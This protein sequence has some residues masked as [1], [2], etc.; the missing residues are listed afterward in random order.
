MLV[1]YEQ[2]PLPLGRSFA[3]R[4]GVHM[5]GFRAHPGEKYRL[6][7]RWPDGDL[8]LRV[9]SSHRDKEEFD[10]DDDED[11]VLA[12]IEKVGPHEWSASWVIGPKANTG[13][14]STVLSGKGVD[15]IE[16][17]IDRE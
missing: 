2:P 9:G 13:I 15:P 12:P 5:W 7:A 11:V 14:L 4:A 10:N 8:E 17:E 16:L 6:R 1:A 3:I